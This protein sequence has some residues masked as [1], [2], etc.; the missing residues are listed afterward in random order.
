[1]IA[2]ALDTQHRRARPQGA[3]ALMSSLLVAVLML[4]GCSTGD[5]TAPHDVLP[6][7]DHIEYVPLQ[8]TDSPLSIGADGGV[9][10]VVAGTGVSAGLLG[11]ARWRQV[12]AA[13]E[14]AE[15]SPLTLPGVREASGLVRVV[16]DG[17][18][19]GFVWLTEEA[20]TEGERIL[21]GVMEE[22]RTEAQEAVEDLRGQPRVEPI[23]GETLLH[24]YDATGR[25]AREVVIRDADAL[26]ALLRRELD[27][28]LVVLPEIDFD[29][30][31]VV[32]VFLGPRSREQFDV[33]IMLPVSR[34]PQPGSFVQVPVT[35][36]ALSE[37]CDPPAGEGG[38]FEIV[39]LPRF[40]EEI[41]FH[42]DEVDVGCT[43]SS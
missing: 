26:L 23:T 4:A 18:I 3:G 37:T 1:M 31:M 29:R 33:K 7:W 5:L 19:L 38:A 10:A 21:V 11:P 36:Y 34:M 6:S 22:V 39:R 28:E 41:F 25:E 8:A 42:W 12:E 9:E 35:R 40:E 13:I 43:G 16:R 24:G 27:R 14:G 30:E 32:A 17:R 2:Q 20:L 15:L